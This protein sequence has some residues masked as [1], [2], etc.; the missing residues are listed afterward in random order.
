MLKVRFWGV[1]GSIPTPGPTTVKVGG[2]TA[3][4]EVRCGTDLV[5]LDAG[6]GLRGLGSALLKEMPVKAHLFISHVHWDHI[7]G[8]PFFVPAFVPG[9]SFQLYGMINVTGTLEET[10]SGQMNYPSFPVR[11]KDMGAE[12]S[13]HDLREG[14]TIDLPA[15]GR[16][17]NAR[18]NHPSGVLGYRL[19]HGG[20]AV[21]YATDTEHYSI[22]DPKLARLAK[23]ADVLIYDATYTPDEYA[24]KIDGV[25]KTGWG[26]S[27]NEE[28]ARIAK[29]LGVRQLVL[30]HHDP[31]QNDEA[32]AEKERRAR[33]I[34]PET[35]A[36]REGLLIEL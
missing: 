3:C 24:G 20:R 15:G 19:E 2:N 7:Q 8:F 29:E 30:F 27:T 23:G 14:Q 35:V 11:L 10:L 13:F 12:M 9:N 22:T 33:A 17:T 32:V 25:P 34:F 26:H 16:I 5:I 4:L 18:L 31:V 21:V 1:R 28:G 36:A 6:T